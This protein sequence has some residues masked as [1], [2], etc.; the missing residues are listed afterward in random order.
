[1]HVISLLLKPLHFTDFKNV[2]SSHGSFV[3]VSTG[4][5]FC[6]FSGYEMIQEP[7]IKANRCD[8]TLAVLIFA[9]PSNV[10]SG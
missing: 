10:L 9:L 3:L 1:M 7:I 8:A 5:A 4:N 2:L 6:S